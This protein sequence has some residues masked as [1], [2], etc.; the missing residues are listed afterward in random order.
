MWQCPMRTCTADELSDWH[1]SDNLS[2]IIYHLCFGSGMRLSRTPWIL[3]HIFILFMVSCGAS[4]C[5]WSKDTDFRGL[6]RHRSICNHYQRASRLASQKRRD[7]AKEVVQ[8]QLTA[9]GVTSTTGAAAAMVSYESISSAVTWTHPLLLL[10]RL[11]SDR[12]GL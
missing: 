10:R 9:T 7:R 11:S 5:S 4:R 6:D 1:E 8:T 12:S 2:S 3:F